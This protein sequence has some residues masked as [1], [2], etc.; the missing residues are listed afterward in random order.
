M[1]QA[2]TLDY[3]PERLHLDKREGTHV[4]AIMNNEL[5]KPQTNHHA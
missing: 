2:G 3:F 5:R 1:R 4:G